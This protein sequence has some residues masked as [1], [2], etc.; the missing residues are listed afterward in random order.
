MKIVGLSV[1]LNVGLTRFNTTKYV[2]GEVLK[3]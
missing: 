3:D 1:G 2:K